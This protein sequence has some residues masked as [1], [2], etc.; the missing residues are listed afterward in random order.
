M[1]LPVEPEHLPPD[2]PEHGQLALDIWDRVRR[3]AWDARGQRGIS[4]T[5]LV[6]MFD[7]IGV[8]P[9]W[10]RQHLTELITAL[11]DESRKFMQK[12]TD[13]GSGSQKAQPDP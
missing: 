4:L 6:A 7:I 1:G 2:L 10:L 3:C 5:D 13:G 11:E 9:G 8:P 12:G